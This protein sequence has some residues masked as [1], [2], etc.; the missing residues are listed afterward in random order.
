MGH[1]SVGTDAWLAIYKRDPA[2]GAL[3]LQE[4][5]SGRDSTRPDFKLANGKGLNLVFMPDGL[6]GF[7]ATPGTLLRSFRRDPNTG[8]LSDISD[9]SEWDRR[10][11]GVD[12]GLWLDGRN[13]FLYGLGCG[14]GTPG[15]R[16]AARRCGRCGWRRS[17]GA[18]CGRRSRR[19]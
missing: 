1:S 18:P 4:A 3:A 16:H 17:A 19:R 6:S 12:A 8:R 11:L 15:S 13:G 7:A 10:V 5:G 9:F 2:S 14:E